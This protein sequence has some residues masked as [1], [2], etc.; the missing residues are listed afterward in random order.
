MKNSL[1]VLAIG[2][3]VSFIAACKVYTPVQQ[4]A[5]VLFEDND[6]SDYIGG[7]EIYYHS[8]SGV[9]NLKDARVS[10]DT[11]YGMAVKADSSSFA[12]A[13]KNDM[14]IYSSND[15][16]IAD[17]SQIAIHKSEIEN[18]QMMGKDI[19]A[20]F[21]KSMSSISLLLIIIISAILIGGLIGLSVWA[22]QASSDGSNASSDQS[23]DSNSDSGSGGSAGSSDGSGC[24]VATMVYGSYEADEVWVLRRFRDNILQKSRGGRWFINWYYSWSPG[25]VA[26]YGKY[27]FI[28]RVA[29]CAIQ[30]LV[31]ILK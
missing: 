25:F 24:Y 13:Q 12:K 8:T 6:I 14:S 15:L 19:R 10:G 21:L 11:I 4:P 3:A 5:S 31:W 17:S 30:P 27:K 26:K 20:S 23:S 18:V 22:S 16:V 1:R 7:Y 9:Y 29:K 2:L 28:H